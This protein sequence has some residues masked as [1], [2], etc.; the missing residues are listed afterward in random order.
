MVL[1]AGHRVFSE[2]EAA[3][4]APLVRTKTLIDTRDFFNREQWRAA[5]FTVRTLG[6]APSAT[7][8]EAQVPA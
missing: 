5:G 2:I 4:V 7:T 6:L 1:L 3:S 8:A